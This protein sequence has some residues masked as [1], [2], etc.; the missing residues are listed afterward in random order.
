MSKIKRVSKKPIIIL[1]VLL[2]I[3][4]VGSYY[5]LRKDSSKPT[6]A[7]NPAG[8]EKT[9]LSPA[10][11]QEKKAAEQHK[12]DLSRPTPQPATTPSGKKQIQPVIT[13][14]NVNGVSAYVGGIFEESG[15]CTAT[16]TMGNQKFTRSSVGFQNATNTGCTP[17]NLTRSDFPASG[18]WLVIIS[19]TSNT[20]EGSS[21]PYAFEVQ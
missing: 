4:A 15:T 12:E 1:A 16:F 11:E 17:I 13:N 21:L 3:L 7:S 19:Y 9:D 5:L 2:L 20:A 14:A 6:P 8:V 10:T 18:S